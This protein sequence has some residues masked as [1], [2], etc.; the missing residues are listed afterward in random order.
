MAGS[1]TKLERSRDGS[2]QNATR[3]LQKTTDSGR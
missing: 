3:G 2:A 1:I